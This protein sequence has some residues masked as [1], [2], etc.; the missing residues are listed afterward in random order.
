MR[1]SSSPSNCRR[2]SEIVTTCVLSVCGRPAFPRKTPRAYHSTL[3]QSTEGRPCGRPS[4]GLCAGSP[5]G[6]LRRD[7]ARDLFDLVLPG[8]GRVLVAELPELDE[9]GLDGLA[10]RAVHP[11]VGEHLDVGADD[12]VGSGVDL[13]DRRRFRLLLLGERLEL[14]RV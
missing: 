4:T 9:R 7:G 6:L 5:G 3:W 10:E 2:S 13:G 11:G 8:V 1:A 12:V 14:L